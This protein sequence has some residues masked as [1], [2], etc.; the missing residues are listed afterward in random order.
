MNQPVIFLRKRERIEV[1][2]GDEWMPG[3]VTDVGV[4]NGTYYVQL[5]G[6]PYSRS[7]ELNMENCR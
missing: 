5:D 6:V 2:V 1:K 4:F 3:T 7:F